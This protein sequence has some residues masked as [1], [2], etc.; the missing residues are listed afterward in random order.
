M[1]FQFNISNI[2]DKFELSKREKENLISLFEFTNYLYDDEDNLTKTFKLR[3]NSKEKLEEKIIEMFE[4]E[5]KE[6]SSI[7]EM[8]E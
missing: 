6:L 7:D 8:E 5:I 1:K 2:L 3:K 4:M